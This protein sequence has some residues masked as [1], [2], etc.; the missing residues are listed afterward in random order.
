MDMPPYEFFGLLSEWPISKVFLRDLDQAWYQ[1][2]VAGLGPL[3]AV[4]ERLHTLRSPGT[5]LIVGNSAGGFA[6]LMLGA[7]TGFEVLAF[8]PQTYLGRWRRLVSW[9][10]RWRA[11]IRTLS[12]IP[13][14]T[15]D[16][17]PF[18]RGLPMRA[19]VH[20]ADRDRLDRHH[21]R[22][23]D[24]LAGIKLVAHPEGDHSLI[25]SLRDSG[26]LRDLISGRLAR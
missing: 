12:A 13:G 26:E 7:L 24:G 15:L 1:R 14:A 22:R 25:R 20:Y 6:A 23:L 17:V 2:G 18:V 5:N 19:E 9:D 21:A 4:A 8:S 3:S 16:V 11:E 10:T